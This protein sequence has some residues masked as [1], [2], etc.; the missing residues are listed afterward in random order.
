MHSLAWLIAANA[1][2]VL[3]AAMLLWPEINDWIAPLTYGRWMP[4]HLNWNLYGWC[5]LPLVG[6]LFWFYLPD[7][8]NAERSANLALWL[9][10]AALFYGGITWLCG[11]SSGR[12]FLD[13]SHEARVFWSVSLFFL[14][15]VLWWQSRRRG[16]VHFWAQ[17]LLLALLVVPFLLYWAADVSVYP[18]INP[19][20]GGPTGASL[21]GSTLAIVGI[22]G[23]LPFLLR[24]EW[25][26]PRRGVRRAYAYCLALSV[27]LYAGIDH[28]HVSH[29]RLDQIAGLGSLVIW[30]PLVWIYARVY[31]WS[32][33]SHSW[34]LAAFLW[35]LILVMS[36]L[37]MFLP[38]ISE[39]LKFTNALVAHSHLAMAGFVT[40]LHMAVLLNLVRNRPTRAWSFWLWQVGCVTHIAALFW[41]G[42]REGDDPSLLYTRGGFADL[43][44][45]LRLIS[46]VAMLLASLGW[47]WDLCLKQNDS[48]TL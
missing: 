31:R 38:G 18:P 21:L 11:R 17:C 15:L 20:S 12:M 16:R 36:G 23:V 45:G 48:A 44:Y 6:V 5:A 10:T 2:G 43:C 26:G 34:L 42:W 25:I 3:L 8:R 9:W 1:I 40:S 27:S 41:L 29:H 46:G 7:D 13:W 19:R 47:L 35:W 14:W 24:L 30:I 33:A 39:R 4:L 37:W 22:S 32:A 28:G